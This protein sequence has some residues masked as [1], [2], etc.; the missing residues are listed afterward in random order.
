MGTTGAASAIL[1]RAGERVAGDRDEDLVRRARA[2]DA[3]AFGAL[4]RRYQDAV[5]A[6][7]RSRVDD[8]PAAEDV[9]QEAFIGAHRNLATIEDPARFAGWLFGIAR[10]KVLVHRRGERR[11]PDRAREGLDPERLDVAAGG[12]AE[13]G[14]D[15]ES[16][17]CRLLDGLSDEA[18]AVLLLRFRDG[19]AYGEIAARLGMPIGTVG[20]ILHRARAAAAANR[21]RMRAEGLSL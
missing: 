16:V 8:G 5:Y 1:T 13:A 14:A 3:G 11:R 15:A 20:T 7:V 21:D 12:E 19:L 10:L 6:F 9:A 17:L 4:V 2:G 18:R